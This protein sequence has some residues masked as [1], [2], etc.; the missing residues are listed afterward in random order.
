MY[1]STTDYV[2]HKYAP[3]TPGPTRFYAMMDRYLAQLDAMGAAIAL[4]ADHGMNAQDARP[5]ARP[6]SST[7]RIARRLARRGQRARDPADHRSLRRAPRRARLL[8]DDLPAD[9]ARARARSRAR[10]RALRGH[11]GRA[12][13]A[14]RPLPR[15][16]L[17]PDRM[18]DLVVVSTRTSCSAR[19]RRATTC[20][21][22]TCRC[23]RTAASPSRRVPL[24]FNR[25]V[26]RP[27]QPTAAAQLRRPRHRA[28]PRSSHGASRAR[29]ARGQRHEA[30]ARGKQRVIEVRNP[31]TAARSSARV[32]K[33][34]AST[35]CASALRDRRTR[36]HA[37]AHPL[38]ARQRSS[39]TRRGAAARARGRGLRPHHRAN[40]ACAKKDSIYEVGRVCDVLHLQRHRRRCKDDGQS[41]S[42]DLTPHGKNRR[43]YTQR[44]PLLGVITRDHAVQPPDEPGGAQGGAR[45]SRPTTAWC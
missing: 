31:Y 16:E 15:F 43:V 29:R 28:E 8:R 9:E 41:F 1:L 30:T 22:S 5:T 39:T 14:R 3:G 6:T 35:R 4:T 34:H 45:R 10:S 21:A 40:R 2:Q 19:A 7:C 24:L 42:C 36:Y 44:E 20:R 32:P 12:R 18:G 23:A 27:R 13:A 33:A 38:R 26:D 25:R 37:D 11:R 17:P